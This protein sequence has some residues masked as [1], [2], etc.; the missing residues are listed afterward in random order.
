M[1]RF[2]PEQLLLRMGIGGRSSI[3]LVAFVSLKKISMTTQQKRRE[4]LRRDLTTP[5]KSSQI[6]SPSLG[7]RRRRRPRAP[8]EPGDHGTGG[9]PATTPPRPIATAESFRSPSA[10]PAASGVPQ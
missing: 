1:S 3:T 8:P 10:V 6:S 4:L 7:L 9:V 2:D 5:A